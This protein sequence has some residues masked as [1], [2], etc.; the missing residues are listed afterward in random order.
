[1]SNLCE[2]YEFTILPRH[3]HN[4]HAFTEMPRHLRKCQNYYITA[5]IYTRNHR[6][7]DKDLVKTHGPRMRVVPEF[8]KNYGLLNE[9][10]LEK[11]CGGLFG[12]RFFTVYRA[13]SKKK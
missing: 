8:S 9:T 5:N 12:S 2:K 7:R 6:R 13:K 3:Y 10:F 11:I 1:M 4:T